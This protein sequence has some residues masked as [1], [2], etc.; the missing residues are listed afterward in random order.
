MIDDVYFGMTPQKPTTIDL[1]DIRLKLLLRGSADFT[2]LVVYTPN[3]DW[4]CVENQT[5][6]TD[7]HNLHAKGL[8][9]ESH[10][11]IVPPG[12]KQSGTLEIELEKY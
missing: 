12:K 11:Q 2:H 8:V 1:R 3:A 9:K 10:L 6:S 5:C 7:A 4:F